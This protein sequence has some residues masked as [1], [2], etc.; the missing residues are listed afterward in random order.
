MVITVY[1]E[2]GKLWHSCTGT[3]AAAVKNLDQLS[4]EIREAFV[5]EDGAVSKYDR[6][7]KFFKRETSRPD[8]G[9]GE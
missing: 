5:I 7:L 9:A 8:S 6:K 4:L 2:G 1:S 3:L